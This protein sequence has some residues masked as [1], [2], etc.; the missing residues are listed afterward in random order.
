VPYVVFIKHFFVQLCLSSNELSCG[1]ERT[2]ISKNWSGFKTSRARMTSICDTNWLG[3]ALETFV[4]GNNVLPTS[5]PYHMS[6]D[7][8]RCYQNI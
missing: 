8:G 7:F 4:A 6:C 3:S 1:L 2:Y 5:S